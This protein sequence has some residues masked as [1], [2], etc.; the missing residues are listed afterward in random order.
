M[1][2]VFSRCGSFIREYSIEVVIFIIAMNLIALLLYGI[3]KLKAKRHAYRIPEAV[4]VG[5]AYLFGAYGALFGMVAFRHKTKHA[6]FMVGIPVIMVLQAVAIFF[7]IK[8]GII[9]L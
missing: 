7:L 6:K 2:A 4:L 1:A 3:D 9:K 8:F 5:V